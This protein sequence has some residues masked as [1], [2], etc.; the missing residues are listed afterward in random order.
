MMNWT[1]PDPGHDLAVKRDILL[2]QGRQ[3]FW[4]YKI[5]WVLKFNFWMHPVGQHREEGSILTIQSYG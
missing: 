5:I 4:K 1:I 3:K 2:Q